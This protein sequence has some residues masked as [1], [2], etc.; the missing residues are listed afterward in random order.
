M[1][2][3]TVLIISGVL[4]LLGGFA[5]LVFPLPA[6]FAVTVFVGWA[7]LISGA[8]GLWAAFSD[9]DMPHRGWSGFF[10]LVDLIVG[11]WMLAQPLPA[12]I[13]LTLVIGALA[14]ASGIVRLYLALTQFR[15]TDMFWM[16]ILSG[17]ISAGLGL[18][19][20]FRLPE[21]SLVL[22]G[23]LFAIE[24]VVIGTTLLSLGLA[25][26]KTGKF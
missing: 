4:A 20:M 11:V 26:R 2:G 8:L 5:A 16:M 12:M 10:S 14:L 17:L 3:T 25:L 18:F 15:G 23:T 9:K 19:V 6:S 21:A 1:K 13:S 24:L 22:L 7:F